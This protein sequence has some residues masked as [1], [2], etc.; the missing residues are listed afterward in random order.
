[1]SDTTLPPVAGLGL[2]TAFATGGW[3]TAFT[4]TFTEAVEETFP[5]LVT[6]TVKLRVWLGCPLRMVGAVNVAV[7]EFALFIVTGVP[8]V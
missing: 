5:A 7:A 3:S 4:V 1:M 2:T 6:F 8:L